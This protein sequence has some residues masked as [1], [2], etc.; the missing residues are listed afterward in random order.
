M[1][2]GICSHPLS[3]GLSLDN[4]PSAAQ[5][6]CEKVE[7]SKRKSDTMKVAM[8]G[9]CG[10]VQYLG[11]T[12]PYYKN[13]I[14]SSKLSEEFVEFRQKQFN[15]FINALQ[16]GPCSVF[17][18]GAGEG[19]HL[20]IFKELGCKTAGIEN[21][22]E[23]VSIARQKGHDVSRGFLDGN[24]NFP[25]L[26]KNKFDCVVSFNFIEHL[27]SPR[28]SLLQLASLLVEDGC[29]LFEVPNYD[30]IDEFK[31]FNEFIPDHRFYFKKD[32]FRTL[33]SLS[34]FEVQSMDTI[35]HDYIISACVKKR[36]GGRWQEYH[37]ERNNL[38]V[39]L[40]LFLE[41]TNP[42]QNAVWGAGHQSLATI[43]N[44]G[45][46]RYLSCVIDSSPKKQNTFCPASALPVCS[47]DVLRTGQI[48]KILLIAAGYN[49]EI[50]SIIRTNFF[51]DF[52]VAIVRYGRVEYAKDNR[53]G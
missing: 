28:G 51:G 4:M 19:E 42:E 2:C 23:L 5:S 21:S 18:L 37:E 44:L 24:N 39:Q 1:R 30:M 41:S 8:C 11:P 25:N 32:T 9:G 26:N 52:V 45:L 33:L 46:E 20:D 6:F 15:S 17:E 31:L 7:A 3:I 36:R 49:D 43:S 48:K 34:G 12:V 50:L 29:G 16:K 10:T 38:K 35:W 40:E 13:T 22:S 27:P 14:R 47:P 53:T